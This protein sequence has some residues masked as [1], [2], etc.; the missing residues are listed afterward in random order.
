MSIQFKIYLFVCGLIALILA[1]TAN[2]DDYCVSVKSVYNNSGVNA[3]ASFG[4]STKL[5]P[6]PK[7]YNIGDPKKISGL[8][9]LKAG[10]SASCKHCSR[11]FYGLSGTPTV[12]ATYDLSHSWSYLDYGIQHDYIPLSACMG[13]YHNTVIT[14]DVEGYESRFSRKKTKIFEVQIKCQQ[15]ST[16][17]PTMCPSS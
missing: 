2:A 9:T 14:Y 5:I 10:T 11:T 12:F 3:D 15:V 13:G 6:A 1:S 16:S 7:D 8:W 4:V 17:E